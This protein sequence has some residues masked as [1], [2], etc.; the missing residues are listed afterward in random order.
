[1]AVYFIGSA[2]EL[3]DLWIAVMEVALALTIVGVR[4]RARATP[5]SARSWESRATW[6]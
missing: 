1:M 3:S 4:V 6:C 5:M 2:A